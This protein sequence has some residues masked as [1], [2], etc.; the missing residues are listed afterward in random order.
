M[1]KQLDSYIIKVPFLPRINLQLYASEVSC[2]KW[3]G[4]LTAFYQ[5]SIV[6][7]IFLSYAVGTI[8]S[9]TYGQSAIIALG[10][11]L[12]FELL[13]ATL[14]YESPRWLLSMGREERAEKTLSWLRQSQEIAK[15]E[16]EEIKRLL[17]RSPRLRLKQ[18]LLE[19]KHRR[20]LIP[21]IL[22]VILIFFHQFSGI[23]VIIFYAAIIFETAGIEHAKETALYAVGGLQIVATFISSCVVDR[24]GRKVLLV[25]GSIGMFL[26]S[27]ALGTHMFLTRPS[28]CQPDNASNSSSSSDS[29]NSHLAPL[30]ISSLMVFGFTF[31][32]GWRALPFIVMS[33]LFPLRLRGILNGFGMC[34][35]WV[36]AGTVTGFYPKLEEALGAYTAWWFFALVS[37]AGIF[38]VIIFLPETKGKSLEEIEAYFKGQKATHENADPAIA[39][40]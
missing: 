40:V 9:V 12:V 35:L 16:A 26:S 4:Q 29:C 36:F 32:V 7:G 15:E 28:N 30:A 25:L 6:V 2:S 17:T 23:N 37:F 33:E 1:S 18:K 20:V 13:T 10:I 24:F 21:L 31:S 38:F 14:S 19:F 34:M 5:L 8:P 39:S 11:V 3:R 27:A 22:S